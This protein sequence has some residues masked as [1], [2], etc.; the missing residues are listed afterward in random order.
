MKVLIPALGVA[1]KILG[2]P[3]RDQRTGRRVPVRTSRLL[4]SLTI[5]LVALFTWF[6]LPEPIA[7][8]LADVLI[9]IG[10]RATKVDSL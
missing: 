9:E 4:A 6:G 2:L 1:G 10:L 5:L 7:E 3:G 8:P